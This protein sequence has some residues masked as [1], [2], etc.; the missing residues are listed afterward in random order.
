MKK[1]IFI[2]VLSILLVIP[3]FCLDGKDAEINAI[4]EVVQIAFDAY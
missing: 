1:I 4:E 3:L 2:V